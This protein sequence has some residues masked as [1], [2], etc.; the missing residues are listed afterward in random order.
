M[1]SPRRC[2]HNA[3]STPP[4]G[5]ACPSRF[6]WQ[7]TAATPTLPWFPDLGQDEKGRMVGSRP[8]SGEDLRDRASQDRTGDIC[9]GRAPAA[10]DEETKNGVGFFHRTRVPGEARLGRGVLPRGGR[11]PRLR[12]PLRGPLQGPED[13]G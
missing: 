10:V 8:L 4:T 7:S 11:T 13:Q 1:R 2:R 3:V 5:A 6:A 12:V 9:S